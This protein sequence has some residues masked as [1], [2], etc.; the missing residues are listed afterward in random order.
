M[1]EPNFTLL[2]LPDAIMVDI[3]ERIDHLRDGL[4]Q[5]D[6]APL[7]ESLRKLERI[8]GNFTFDFISSLAWAAEAICTNAASSARELTRMEMMSLHKAI[9]SMDRARHVAMAAAA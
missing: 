9:V 5:R 7:I 6:P 4:Q 1:S 8:R 3:Q 2:S